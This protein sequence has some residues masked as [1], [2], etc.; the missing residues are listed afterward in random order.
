MTNDH[1]RI[2]RD[3]GGRMQAGFS[4][5]ELLIALTIGVFLLAGVA[6]VL[7]IT[8]QNFNAQAGMGQLQDDQRIAVNMLVMVLGHAGYYYNPQTETALT[9]FPQVLPFAG[10]GQAIAGT[11]GA[12]VVADSIVVRYVQSPPGT[13]S[14][15]FLQ[16]CNGNSNTDIVGTLSVNNFT[17]DSQNQLTCAVGSRPA[18]PLASGISAFTVLYGVD[19]DKDNSVD[20]YLP[21]LAM[22]PAYWALVVSVQVSIDFINPLDRARPIKVKRVIKLMGRA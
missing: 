16:D 15:D 5:L 9:S 19:R 7:A 3:T 11:S 12:G 14:S 10:A 22:T 1:K 6:A 20:L 18:Q 17:L 2:Q 4:L 13:A 21:A 8:R